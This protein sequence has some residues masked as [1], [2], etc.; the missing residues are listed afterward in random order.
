MTATHS[1]RGPGLADGREPWSARH[2]LRSARRDL[3]RLRSTATEGRS[4]A[5]PLILVG[6]WLAVLLVLVPLVVAFA[7]LVARLVVG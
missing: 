5:T 3:G 7:T 4:A 2:P 1:V 6:A